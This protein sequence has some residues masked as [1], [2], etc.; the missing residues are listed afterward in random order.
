MI[1]LL[2]VLAADENVR[3]YHRGRLPKYELSPPSIML[4]D[5]DGEALSQGPG[6]HGT[7]ASRV[8]SGAACPMPRPWTW[9]PTAIGERE[10]VS[11]T[12]SASDERA[13][14]HLNK[15][16]YDDFAK[17]RSPAKAQRVCV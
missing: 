17:S 13:S 16:P 2:T 9:R 8:C 7:H 10:V 5:G 3:H 12:T 1:F 11:A 14:N 6:A 4:S 15:H